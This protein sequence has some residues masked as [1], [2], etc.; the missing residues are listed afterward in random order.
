GAG[1]RGRHLL[2][3]AAKEGVL[4]RELRKEQV[5]GRGSHLLSLEELRAAYADYPEALE[6]AERIAVACSLS[7]AK[8][9]P[10]VL[11][12]LDEG[13]NT[14]DAAAILAARCRSGFEQRYGRS[15]EV[16]RARARA[17]LDRELR[18]VRSLCFDDYFL[19]VDE[20]VRLARREGI[21]VLGRGSAADSIVSYCLG[22]TDADPLRYGLCFERFLNPARFEQGGQVGLPDIDLDF[23]WRRRDRLLELVRDRF[24]RER[25]AMFCTHP[26]LGFR[27]AYREAARCF[28]LGQAEVDRRSRGLPRKLPGGVDF[29]R[30]GLR[31]LF[32]ET[33]ILRARLAKLP[34][35]EAARIRERRIWWG[36]FALTGLQRCLGLHPGGTVLSPVPIRDLAGVERSAKGLPVLQ[37]DKRQAPHM[38][39]VKIDLLGNRAL[40]ILE[41]ARREVFRLGGDPEED[42]GLG[43]PGSG[44]QA[45]LP[46]GD[47][48]AESLLAQ[49]RT[50]GVSQIE[51]PGMR[52]LLIRM[53]ASSLDDLIQAIALI[54]PGPAGSGMLDRYVRRVRGEEA[55]PELPPALAG[56]LAESK[57]VLLYQE[58]VSRVL[59]AFCGTD[60]V[61][62]DLLRRRVEEGDPG[63][64]REFFEAAA[65]REVPRALAEEFWA[66]VQ[67]FAGFSFNK[68][69]AV[70]YGRLSW[71]LLRLKA[72]HPAALF[73]ALLASETGYYSPAVYVEEAKRCGITILPPCVNRS[74][75]TF[76]ISPGSTGLS[77]VATGGRNPG[78]GV[79][80]WGRG[81]IRV[82]L[83]EVR[84]MPEGFVRG[85]LEERA[86][87]GPFFSV[88]GFV[89]RMGRRRARAV[90][91]TTG[92]AAQ[93]LAV[94][95]AWVEALI[96]VG[97]FDLCEGT[98]GEKL[99]RF[100]LEFQDRL[101]AAAQADE[102]AL[103]PEALAPRTPILPSLPPFTRERR[104][105]IEARLLGFFCGSEPLEDMARGL[106]PLS[107][108]HPQVG[109]RVRVLGH[110]AALRGHRTRDGK[111]M[112]F[113]TLEDATGMLEAVLFPETWQRF[114][115][116]LAEAPVVFLEGLLQS[117]EGALVL[118]VERVDRVE[119]G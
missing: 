94:Q 17:R 105:E 25:F 116:V 42:G 50:L 101:R 60:L 36:A 33:P 118:E 83:G 31:R 58:D 43:L 70:T 86:E 69:H 76:S 37:W 51:S 18:V 71:R 117:R 10:L 90:R 3:V 111:Q 30:E 20:I 53:Q 102:P 38:G 95:E 93:D 103:F 22:F 61:Q 2:A 100:R 21:P 65:R 15:S 68:A 54:R 98:R 110:V 11:P 87:G 89:E 8:P 92:T 112:C 49:G 40:T 14:A 23:C 114:G 59:A 73:S 77:A 113:A 55:M 28:G 52:S 46:T 12:V 75:A 24:G 66:Q 35:G 79:P 16:D 91:R 5:A 115:A 26:S 41:D 29:S 84:G 34:G 44:F 99:W 106:L 109:Q 107:D 4:L 97:A 78:M 27:A 81:A 88:G 48:H 62:G 39:L 7:L 13:R 64:R 57:G 82:G 63:A 108:L 72:R 85:I 6:E 9:R 74:A 96:L 80:P 67:R 56:I 19:I 45:E 32:A 1:E 104:R 47:P 119:H